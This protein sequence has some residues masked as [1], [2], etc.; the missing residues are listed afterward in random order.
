MS[1]GEDQRFGESLAEFG[2]RKTHTVTGHED[3]VERARAAFINAMLGNPTGLSP[4]KGIR[5]RTDKESL[6]TWSISIGASRAGKI[7]AEEAR[8]AA[9]TLAFCHVAQQA[10]EGTQRVYHTGLP[11]MPGEAGLAPED[12][13]PADD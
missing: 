3:A 9:A 1:A 13:A 11:K 2:A 12:S 7:V 10:G 4:L 6:S 5:Q 8:D